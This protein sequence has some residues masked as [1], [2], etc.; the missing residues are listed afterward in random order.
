[1]SAV[2]YAVA[3]MDTKGHELAFVARLIREAGVDVVTVDVGTVPAPVVEHDASRDA[4]ACEE[5]I[6]E[7]LTESFPASDP[8]SWMPPSRIGSPRRER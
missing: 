7:S 8:P 6:D 1:M 3:T 5:R 4:E 2:V